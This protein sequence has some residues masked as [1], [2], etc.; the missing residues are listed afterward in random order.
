[1]E[2]EEGCHQQEAQHTGVCDEGK[3]K[4][5]R[6]HLTCRRRE[7][8]IIV[9]RS[10]TNTPLSVLQTHRHPLYL[11]RSHT[12]LTQTSLTHTHTLSLSL[13]HT[14]FSHTHHTHT[15]LLLA[16]LS[17]SPSLPPPSLTRDEHDPGH[18]K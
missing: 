13:T 11:S 17:I 10:H 12:S 8:Q 2:E 1:M 9:Q 5:P 6:C 18:E 3:G 7:G 16:R 14:H 4:G 15:H